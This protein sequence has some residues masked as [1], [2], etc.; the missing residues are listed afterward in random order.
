MNRHHVPIFI[1]LAVTL[2][3]TT[4]PAFAQCCGDCNDDG[5]V[6][7]NEIL[8]TVDNA[9]DGCRIV[10][11]PVPGVTQTPT[12]AP[13]PTALPD[14]CT[15]D[16]PGTRLTVL[17]TDYV[18][19]EYQVLLEGSPDT[20]LLRYPT[21]LNRSGY[22][23][24]VVDPIYLARNCTP[25]SGSCN[26]AVQGSICGFPA[27]F[28]DNMA[29]GGVTSYYSENLVSGAPEW[30]ISFWADSFVYR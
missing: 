13:T 21:A 25:F 24:G 28:Q 30:G 9:L 18:V 16:A 22:L 23:V 10:S 8:T 6:T 15:T 12:A 26:N 7:I 5:K 4:A 11:T 19:I 29:S 27:V 20:Y 3:M 17:G 14:Q 1:L 2:A